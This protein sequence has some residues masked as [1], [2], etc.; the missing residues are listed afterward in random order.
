MD[1]PTRSGASAQT[2]PYRSI[3]PIPARAR[4]CMERLFGRDFGE[5]R[6]VESDLPT[7]IGARAFAFGS[8]V[9]VP[10]VAALLA[11]ADGWR[12]LGHELTHVLQQRD[13]R[14]AAPRSAGSTLLDDADLEAEADRMGA[15]AARAF[16]RSRPARAYHVPPV[17]PAGARGAPVVQCAMTLDEFKTKTAT[18]GIRSLD[19]ISGIDDELK[20]FHELSMRKP[21]NFTAISKSA[22]KVYDAAKKFKAQKPDSSRMPGVDELI[23]QLVIEDAIFARLAEFEAETDEIKKF[24]I[25]EKAQEGWFKQRTRGELVN[26]WIDGDIT[27]LMNKLLTGNKNA[28]ALVGRDIDSLIEI[29]KDPDTPALLSAV[30]AECTAARNTQ[31]IDMA[32]NTPGLKYNQSRGGTAK[33]TLNHALEQSLGK[34]FRM[35]SLLHELTHLSNAEIFGNT[36]LM[37]AISPGASDSEVIKVA[38]ARNAKIA[39]LLALID[40]EKSVFDA[41]DSMTITQGTAVNNRLYIEFKEKCTYPV[42]GKF[43]NQYLR[44]FKSKM[45]PAV[46]ARLVDLNSK[47]LDCELTEYD[48][49]VNQM[50]L[51]SYLYG[52]DKNSGIYQTLEALVREAQAHRL[53]GRVARFVPPNKPL[54]VPPGRPLPGR[55]V[56]GPPNK[57]LPPVP[58]RPGQSKV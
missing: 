29:G 46:H 15:A 36:C 22:R 26:K 28:P 10:R 55:V 39:Q 17:H 25:L 9:F 57:P 20:A 44:V 32:C 58:V 4:R 33:Y 31:Q 7:R 50:L 51:W 45:D 53:R 19:K 54:P 12:L 21:R 6:L 48:S 14:A 16:G 13:G 49:V 18:S 27:I 52:M 1:K 30:I 3:Q 42:S 35:G 5:V 34:R 43:G 8:D 11:S 24:A 40:K 56:G 41:M 47:G 37:L 2:L 23:R 38:K